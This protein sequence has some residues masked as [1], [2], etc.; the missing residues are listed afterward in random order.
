MSF[1]CYLALIAVL[2]LRP[3]DLA[4]ELAGLRLYLVTVSLCLVTSLLALAKKLTADSLRSEPLHAAVLAYLAIQPLSLVLAG[5]INFVTGGVLYG[6]LKMA[7][8]F[9]VT[10]AVIDSYE[11]FRTL[12]AVLVL[13]ISVSAL[14]PVLQYHEA[15]D[16]P[17]LEPYREGQV[18]PE[19]GE[20]TG[21]VRLRGCGMFADPNDFCLLMVL[22]SVC[23][24]GLAAT[25]T[26]GPVRA[27][28]LSPIGL[29]G[30]AITLTHSRGG[31]LAVLATA[32]AL[33]Y[34]RVGARRALLLAPVLVVAGALAAGGRQANL[35][36]DNRDDT[37]QQRLH[38]WAE[39]FALFWSNPVTG[40][41]SGQFA[42]HA[43]FVAHNSFVHAFIE[44]GFVGG[45]L[46]VCLFALPVLVLVTVKP[47]ARP[48]RLPAVHALRGPVLGLILGYA[49][50]CFSL[51]RNM[52]EPTYLVLGLVAAYLS[53]PAV[54][55]P[56]WYVVPAAWL[57][58]AA[59]LGATVFI[60]LRL[61]VYLMARY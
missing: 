47:P 30:Y 35:D 49:A 51:S 6:C 37:S 18:D 3:E 46:F 52:I 41:G 26:A 14:L 25:T 34:N 60:G 22:G 33:L 15:I 29:F 39:G 16:I 42:E 11:R 4:P 12:L 36:L 17:T 21:N 10:V 40:L 43:G 2:L 19:T 54:P 13:V 5:R 56:G 20:F 48:G 55:K 8:C 31:M 38:L 59:V 23:C 1:P 7:V 28:W 27:L 32:V 45:T 9:F 44:T 50:G 57:K 58:Y 24:V 61:F 53:L